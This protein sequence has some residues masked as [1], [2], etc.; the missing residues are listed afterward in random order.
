MRL[1]AIIPTLNEAGTLPRLVMCLRAEVDEIVV[2][3]GGSSDATSFAGV[4]RVVCDPGRGH[5]LNT[6]ARVAT[7]DLLWFLHADT[8]VPAGAGAV[9]RASHAAWGCFRVKVDSDRLPLRWTG[10]VM[11][12]R[13]RLTGSCTGDMGIWARR[14]L[15]DAVGGFPE[16]PL[17]ED[18]GFTDRARGLSPGAVL[19]PR[20]LTS[21]RRW[22]AQGVA[23]TAARMLV[24][25]AGYRL[26]CDPASLVRWYR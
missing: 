24:V 15:F 18:L 6:G 2:A 17:C 25:R 11:T 26:G 10:R 20:L 7:G 16:W 21:A 23:R 13:A 4:T 3:D 5:Q 9:V 8:D 12:L 1:S 19:S 22:E 14:E